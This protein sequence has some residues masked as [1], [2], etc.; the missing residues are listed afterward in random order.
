VVLIR[1]VGLEARA[2]VRRPEPPVAGAADFAQSNS[3][4]V[5]APPA[6]GKKRRKRKRIGQVVNPEFWLRRQ[7]EIERLEQEDLA[8]K[9][10]EAQEAKLPSRVGEQPRAGVWDALVRS[11]SARVVQGGAIESSRRRH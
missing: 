1:V 5:A 3:V 10:V 9:Q 6:Q 7:Q 2:R 4:G 8:R 11:R